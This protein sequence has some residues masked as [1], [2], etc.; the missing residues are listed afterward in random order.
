MPYGIEIEYII[1]IY[2]NPVMINL[3]YKVTDNCKIIVDRR[4]F[5]RGDIFRSSELRLSLDEIKRMAH[6]HLISSMCQM[7]GIIESMP[8]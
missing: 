4:I 1:D 2:N 8:E 5:L 6:E 3:S 7:L